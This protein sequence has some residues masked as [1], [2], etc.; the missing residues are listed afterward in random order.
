MDEDYLASASCCGYRHHIP[1]VFAPSAAPASRLSQHAPSKSWCRSHQ[2]RP[3]TRCR[4]IVGEKLS[5]R[6]G[7]PVVI[8][9]KAEARAGNLGAEA[10]ARAE[11]DGYTLLSSPPPPLAI[12]HTLP[13]PNCHFDPKAFAPVIDTGGSSQMCWS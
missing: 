10:V 9:N 7:Q 4:S 2:G 1:V 8:E 12:N 6:W 3:S 13:I 11:P 5:A